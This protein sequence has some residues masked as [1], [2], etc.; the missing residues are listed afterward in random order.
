MILQYK[1][2]NGIRKGPNAVRLQCALLLVAA[3]FLGSFVVS[4]F[5][6]TFAPD[7]FADSSYGSY[8]TYGGGVLAT[9]IKL[10]I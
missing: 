10:S 6:F 9:F 2:W 1:N 5:T 3:F 8:L 4:T 7:G